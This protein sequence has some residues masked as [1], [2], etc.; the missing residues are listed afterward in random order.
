MSVWQDDEDDQPGNAPR[1][2]MLDVVFRISCQ[3]LP[4]DHASALSTA[5]VSRAPWVESLSGTGIQ[6]I[7]VA[8]SQNGWERPSADGQHIDPNSDAELLLSR[9]TRL[10]IRIQRD[11]AARLID[12]LSGETLSIEHYPLAIN[13]GEARELTAATTLFSR[14]THFDECDARFADEQEIIDRVINEC[15][16]IGFTP[17]R[18]MC[19]LPNSLSH[20]D[21]P[22]TTRS[23]LIANVPPE[24]SLLLQATG[25]G[26][27]R[28]IGCGVVIPHKDTTAV[29]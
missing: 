16:T 17:T 27:K 8:G 24:I 19:G 26:Q 28:L 5:I 25:I 15:R 7:H 11:H 18:L 12:S 6:P 14:Y 21:G 23:V 9:R 13:Q 4:I 3:K 1:C 2:D 10:R 22:I 29:N 20:S